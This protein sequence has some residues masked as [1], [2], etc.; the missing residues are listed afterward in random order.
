MKHESILLSYPR[1]FHLS[2]DLGIQSPS[3]C[4]CDMGG[5]SVFGNQCVGNNQ[6]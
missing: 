3:P 6:I 2:F 1:L 5:Y 4:Q